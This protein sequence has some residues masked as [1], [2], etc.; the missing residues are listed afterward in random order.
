MSLEWYNL[1]RLIN[2]YYQLT[3]PILS[4]EETE[5]LEE[6]I[7]KFTENWIIIVKQLYNEVQEN[8]RDL[9]K[10]IPLYEILIEKAVENLYQILKHE[11]LLP[12]QPNLKALWAEQLRKI[13]FEDWVRKNF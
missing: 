12:K 13:K 8:L 4:I 5:K 6:Y 11:N 3:I 10:K 7:V 2:E 9:S 1:I